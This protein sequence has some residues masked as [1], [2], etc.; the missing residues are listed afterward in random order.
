[1]L[2]SDGLYTDDTGLFTTLNAFFTLTFTVDMVLKIIGFGLKSY[3]RD[4]MNIFD[5]FIVLISL[6]ELIFSS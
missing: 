2:A 5:S 1:M 3:F 6:A 4:K